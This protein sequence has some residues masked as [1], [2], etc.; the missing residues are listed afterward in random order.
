MS[1]C[2]RM[3]KCHAV[4][5]CAHKNIFLDKSPVEW[6]KVP[7]RDKLGPGSPVAAKWTKAHAS[8]IPIIRIVWVYQD[9]L[10]SCYEQLLWC[11]SRRTYIYLCSVFIPHGLIFTY[12]MS[13]HVLWLKKGWEWLIRQMVVRT[14]YVPS[15]TLVLY[16][17]ARF[18]RY[19]EIFLAV[20][21][22]AKG[23]RDVRMHS[24]L[25][26]WILYSETF[27]LPCRQLWEW[28]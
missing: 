8:T 3:S 2:E 7:W 5:A 19:R 22:L 16:F 28:E 25:F 13:S 11:S 21:N 6:Q 26:R 24:I 10:K 4:W 17:M 9:V 14:I 12:A 1:N 20:W 27:C 23:I 18:S 15:K